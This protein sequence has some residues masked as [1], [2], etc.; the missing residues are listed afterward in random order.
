MG[1]GIYREPGVIECGTQPGGCGV[2]CDARGREMCCNVTRTCG[3]G[4]VRLVTRVT[5]G[6]RRRVRTAHVTFDAG[7]ADVG[8]GQ[9]ELRFVVIER[10][11]RPRCRRM[12]HL[13]CGWESGLN[14]IR[15]RSAVVVRAMAGH[16]TAVRDVVVAAHMARS[17]G[18]RSMESSQREARGR[19]IKRGKLPTLG[20]VAN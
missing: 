4:E 9:G 12:A 3:A 1:P 17:T 20:G 19:V 13:A 2:A 7:D 18:Q 10:G 15:I 14:V 16:T 6:R 11:R 5:I 8:T